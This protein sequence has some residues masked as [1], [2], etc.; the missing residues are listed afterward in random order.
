MTRRRD[1][2]VEPENGGDPC[3]EQAETR[4]CNSFACN[5][6]CVLGD[7]SEWGLCSKACDGGHKERTKAIKV[8]KV[9]QGTCP[10]W[11]DERRV[12]FIAC[13][14]HDCRT[15]I[16]TTR[17]RVK[18]SYKADIFL[19]LDGSGSLGSYGWA[20]TQSAA[21]NLVDSMIGGEEGVN[22]A[23]ELFSGPRSH[24]LLDACTGSD[25]N[26]RPDPADCGI[27]WVHRLSNDMKSVKKAVKKMKWPRR[28]TLTSLA[29]AEVN[30]Q[31]IQGRQDAPTIVIVITDGKPMHEDKTRKASD[32]LKR[33]ARLMWVPVGSAVKASIANMRKWAS[34]P[35]QDNVLEVDS[36]AALDTPT[37]LNNIIAGFCPQLE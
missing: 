15:L 19:M 31:A 24:R 20:E 22:I 34:L 33:S 5:A 14:T 12:D 35:W 11:D 4:E 29:L 37:T 7:W 28:T 16:P 17:T 27:H 30:S 13:N 3:P 23:V 26:E 10:K 1:K 36:F 9:G 21:L 6:D 2:T 25:P 32:E 18:C 8:E